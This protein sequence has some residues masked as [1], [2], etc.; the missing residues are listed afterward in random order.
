MTHEIWNGYG[1]WVVWPVGL[2]LVY[3]LW[4][5]LCLSLAKAPGL[6]GHVRWARRISRW[7]PAVSWDLEPID[8]NHH[9]AFDQTIARSF[10]RSLRH[11]WHG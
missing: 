10:D 2:W 7:L 8:V 11:Q 6:I 5:R 9:L 1:V 3:R 4:H